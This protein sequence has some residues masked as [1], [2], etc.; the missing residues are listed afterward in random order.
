M[1]KLFSKRR[2]VFLTLFTL[3]VL[4]FFVPFGA[5]ASV[6]EIFVLGFGSLVQLA[7]EFLG[8]ILIAVIDMLVQ[9]AQYND[10]GDSTAVNIGWV[11][12]RDLAN[13]LFIVALIV[14]SFGTILQWEQYRYNRLL[15]KLVLTV[16]LVNFSKAI[17]LLLIDFSQVIMMTFVNAFRDVAAGNLTT[18][19]GIRALLAYAESST[20]VDINL[21]S[22]VLVYALAVILILIA[23]VVTITLVVILLRR[24]ISL[25]III[26]LSPLAFISSIMPG[27]VGSYNSGWWKRLGQE[28]FVGPALAFFLWLSFS[29]IF[30]T[31]GQGAQ[32]TATVVE[33]D[34]GGGTVLESN[35]DV[36]ATVSQIGSTQ[37]LF[38]FVA[39]I[40]LLIHSMTIAQQAG[41]FAGKFASRASGW[42]D[43]GGSKIVKG[44]GGAPKKLA[45]FTG[46][47]GVAK[48][49][50]FTLA[51][52]GLHGLESSK[53]LRSKGLGWTGFANRFGAARGRLNKRRLTQEDKDARDMQF[54]SSDVLMSMAN[55]SATTETSR[56]RKKAATELLM[57]RGDGD[58]ITA[59]GHRDYQKYIGYQERAEKQPDGTYKLK[60][61]AVDQG[62]YVKY[63]SWLKENPHRWLDKDV[64]EERT[65]PVKRAAIGK[66][67]SDVEKLREKGW[68]DLDTDALDP[69][70]SSPLTRRIIYDTFQRQRN[71]E[72]LLQK[73]SLKNQ[74][75]LDSE[76]KNFKG[77]P[78]ATPEQYNRMSEAEQE[79]YDKITGGVGAGAGKAKTRLDRERERRQ[80]LHLSEN[81]DNLQDMISYAEALK[82]G[83]ITD[84]SQ[85]LK[86]LHRILGVEERRKNGETVDD[87]ISSL[88]E[89]KKDSARMLDDEYK[90]ALAV[91]LRPKG[92]SRF[93]REKAARA[94]LGIAEKSDNVDA[95]YAYAQARRDKRVRSGKEFTADYSRIRPVDDRLAKGESIDDIVASLELYRASSEKM[96]DTEYV[97]LIEA[98][99]SQAKARKLEAQKLEDEQ[100]Q[101][102]K[103]NAA[104]AARSEKPLTLEEARQ[105]D[106]QEKSRTR[107][108]R[109]IP[110][111][112]DQTGAEGADDTSSPDKGKKSPLA[113]GEFETGEA[114]E[115]I[116]GRDVLA[117]L[118]DEKKRAAAQ[119]RASSARFIA[120][121]DKLGLD[122]TKAGM[123]LTGE[124]KR[125]TSQELQKMFR[126][127][128][129]QAGG[130]DAATIEDRVQEFGKAIDEAENLV[131]ANSRQKGYTL[132]HVLRHENAHAEVDKLSDAEKEEM[133][134][135]L[136]PAEQQRILDEIGQKWQTGTMPDK[137]KRAQAIEEY[138]TEGLANYGRSDAVG[139]ELDSDLALAM[140]R[141]GVKF[142][143]YAN[144]EQGAPQAEASVPLDVYTKSLSRYEQFTTSPT[145]RDEDYDRYFADD[146]KQGA[147]LDSSKMRAKAVR[148]GQTVRLQGVRAD[149]AKALSD[150]QKEEE[151]EKKSNAELSTKAVS[152]FQ[153]RRMNWMAQKKAQAKTALQSGTGWIQKELSEFID[154]KK[155]AWYEGTGVKTLMDGTR[156]GLQ[157]LQEKRKQFFEKRRTDRT[158]E[159]LRQSR[160]V[161]DEYSEKTSSIHMEQLRKQRVDAEQKHNDASGILTQ[162]KDEERRIQRDIANYNKQATSVAQTGNLDQAREFAAQAREGQNNLGQV[163]QTIKSTEQTVAQTQK[164][165]DKAQEAERAAMG[166]LFAST[167]KLSKQFDTI[168]ASLSEDG[169]KNLGS[170]ASQELEDLNVQSLESAWLGDMESA[171]RNQEKANGFD[172]AKKRIESTM[173]SRTNPVEKIPAST[174]TSQPV[175]RETL[176]ADS[177]R[178]ETLVRNLQTKINERLSEIQPTL[179]KEMQVEDLM[180]PN[181]LVK[182]NISEKGV[183]DTVRKEMQQLYDT[184]RSEQK[185]LR[186]IHETLQ[187]QIHLD[188]E[189]AHE[190]GQAIERGIRSADRETRKV[191]QAERQERQKQPNRTDQSRARENKD[192]RKQGPSQASKSASRPVVE[193]QEPQ[194]PN[195]TA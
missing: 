63:K 3:A 151:A 9:V 182:K 113:G 183:L 4:L 149:Q 30:L 142:R 126:Q 125:R 66:M 101:L 150:A 47:T 90:A 34:A 20:S 44:I 62:A 55:G 89:Y 25:W 12:T 100:A 121:F 141:K 16:V 74:V 143:A 87:I 19:F 192:S 117:R 17:S 105:L 186:D 165:L 111:K 27:G 157:K 51:D 42:I 131:I 23:L 7:V 124:E 59:K 81:T 106:Q 173:Q 170:L 39:V 155:L 123:N 103:I 35:T 61:N 148:D 102:A 128:L 132:G 133:F 159:P 1:L 181:P 188:K 46:A 139:S 76:N 184:F 58:D 22:T 80:R 18:G 120:D 33:V 84:P 69:E 104:R 171:K 122:P 174:V 134:G 10:F 68:I 146:I 160:D 86:P 8:K 153:L 45:D 88:K 6:G 129:E 73:M 115:L 53:L 43:Q 40:V 164:G 169:L 50:G 138:L 82:K 194:D 158:N 167:D 28:M 112:T 97:N 54:V 65:E 14:I 67:R 71:K 114:P 83:T 109:I 147:L 15:G 37:N 130:L 189:R 91:T 127:Q 95:M 140:K 175:S 21:T 193:P 5:H 108:P 176:E 57:G 152:D 41:G 32:E 135:I 29:I 96:S 168:T 137:E 52:K 180:N 163:Q 31:S 72:R 118:A 36:Q 166:R 94:Q 64:Q 79:E 161:V 136:D 78:T 190:T 93:E 56:A 145:L 195:L 13:M 70:L 92:D 48:R 178:Q 179:P 99:Q 26:I 191:N 75:R 172:I 110:P 116:A 49:A 60:R 177:R 107:G 144:I 98:E 154:D 38:N 11:I 156:A 119:G 2:V 24:I 162:L 185:T 85:F 187:R 77:V